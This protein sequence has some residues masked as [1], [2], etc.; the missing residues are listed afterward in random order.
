MT[1]QSALKIWKSMKEKKYLEWKVPDV[2]FVWRNNDRSV[3]VKNNPYGISYLFH[4][5]VHKDKLIIWLHTRTTFVIRLTGKITTKL[6][7]A[8]KSSP[9]T[10]DTV[11]TRQTTEY[12]LSACKQINHSYRARLHIR[13]QSTYAPFSFTLYNIV[14]CAYAYQIFCILW[15]RRVSDTDTQKQNT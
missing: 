15:V 1:N 12:L 9:Q 3:S 6:A 5:L 7:T 2:S 10:A 13:K 11:D 4:Y 14:F 8:R